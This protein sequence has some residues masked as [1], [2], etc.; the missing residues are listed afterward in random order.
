MNIMPGKVA[1][2][3]KASDVFEAVGIASGIV[4]VM[5]D[6]VNKVGGIVHLLLPASMSKSGEAASMSAADTALPFMLGEMKELGA[7]PSTIEVKA[8]GGSSLQGNPLSS[9]LGDRIHGAILKTLEARGLF[10]HKKDIGGNYKRN[11]HFQIS[12]G[13]L[14]IKSFKR[15]E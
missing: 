11:V 3:K 13:G 2:S 1:V 14:Q 15:K 9:S 5:Y 6:A 7:D 12:D 10:L 8:V 4:V